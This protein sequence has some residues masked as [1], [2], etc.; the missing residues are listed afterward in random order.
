M[1]PLDIYLREIKKYISAKKSVHMFIRA[2]FKI[3]KN[4]T[5]IHSVVGRQ[6][7]VYNC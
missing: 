4:N 6:I 7:M 1:L 5:N 3:A 2:I